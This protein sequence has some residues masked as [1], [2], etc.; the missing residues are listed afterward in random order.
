MNTIEDIIEW[1]EEYDNPSENVEKFT[2]ELIQMIMDMNYAASNG[3][4]AVGYAGLIG[5]SEDVKSAIYLTVEN[6]TYNSNGRYSF[7]NDGVNI[8]NNQV[9]RKTLNDVVGRENSKT[10]IDGH[11]SEDGTRSKYSFGNNLSLNDVVSQNFMA[12]NARGD[13]MLLIEESARPDSV[14]GTTEIPQLMRDP[15]VTHILGIPKDSLIGFTDEE[16]FQILKEKSLLMQSGAS[17]YRG[18]VTDKIGDEIVDEKLVSLEQ[19]RKLEEYRKA[20]NPQKDVEKFNAELIQI[21][22]DITTFLNRTKILVLF[23]RAVK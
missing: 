21:I 5:Y 12:A 11:W 7:I 1:I 3:G 23:K 10:I 4:A 9:F 8:L 2:A 16:R 18:T 15:K 22:T 6:L 17:V 14:L 20:Y 13:V 19:I